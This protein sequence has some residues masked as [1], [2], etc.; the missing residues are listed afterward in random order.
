MYRSSIRLL[1]FLA[2]CP[3]SASCTQLL[4]TKALVESLAIESPSARAVP[5]FHLPRKSIASRTPLPLWEE[6]R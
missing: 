6:L 1:A 4:G 3:F 2:R 5:V